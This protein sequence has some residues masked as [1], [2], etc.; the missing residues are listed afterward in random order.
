MEGCR[1]VILAQADAGIDVI[2]L[3]IL[4]RILWQTSGNSG[5][6]LQSIRLGTNLKK[7]FDMLYKVR[8][9]ITAMSLLSL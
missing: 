9:R 7:V 6:L 3:G 2:E 1:D 8:G 4:F 5:S